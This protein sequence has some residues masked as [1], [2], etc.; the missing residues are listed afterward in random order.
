QNS[1]LGLW[2]QEKAYEQSRYKMVHLSDALRLGL[3]WMHGGIYLDLDVVVLVKLGAFV[4]SLVQS[5][6]DMVAN[7]ILFFD[8]YHPFLGDCIRTLVSNYNPHVWGQNGPVLMRSVF[9]RWCNATIVE[10]MVG[11]SCKGVTLLPR[12]YFLPLNYSQHSKF[13]RD[14]DAE[15]VWNA[16]GDSHIVHVYGSNSAD[17]IAEPRSVYATVARRHCPRT[18]ALSMKLD[19]HI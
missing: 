9:L 16:S 19:G 4:N 18:F 6:N 15:E 2:L 14:S 11:K 17:V 1:S 12:R 7:G 10:D 13:F 5:M 8:R 3:L